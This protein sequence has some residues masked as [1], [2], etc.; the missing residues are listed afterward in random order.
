VPQPS[1]GHRYGGLGRRT[2]ATRDP[3]SPRWAPGTNGARLVARRTEKTRSVGSPTRSVRP[4]RRPTAPRRALPRPRDS[5]WWLFGYA[6][7]LVGDQIFYVALTWVAVTIMSPAE[8]GL[9][10]VLGSLPRAVV[11]LAGGVFVDRIGPKRVIIVSDVLRT[12][13]MVAAAVLFGIGA[14]GTLLIG[15]LAAVFGVV[16]GFF[17][18]A[19]G[20]APAFVA[21]LEAQTRLQALRTVVYRGAPMVGAPLAS[22]LLVAYGAVSAFGVAAFMFAASV[23]AL[24]LTRMTRPRPEEDDPS[25]PVG[26]AQ[27]VFAEIRDGLRLVSRDRRL[28]VTVVVLAV[29]DF[30][31][32]GPMTA[33]VPLLAAERGWGAGGIGWVLGGFGVGAVVTAVLLTWRRPTVRAGVVAATGLTLMSLGLLALGLV[34]LAGLAPADEVV[35]AG[36]CG[37]LAGVG[38]GLFGTLINASL[39]I[40]TPV[41]QL[42][43][44]M[45]VAALA[46]YVGDPV[47]FSLTGITSQVLGASS[48]FLFGGGF[49]MV[50]VVIT[51]VSPAIRTLALPGTERRA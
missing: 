23:V 44:V 9:V 39:V 3:G 32:A 21:T 22:A 47:S 16:D 7:S 37:A 42:G 46:G 31:F 8:V 40:S 29:L 14:N 11:L 33:G 51:W 10:L 41:R 27:G 26:A 45:A 35:L 17:L 19:V 20:A 1:D 34:D 12:L 15:A 5:G 6:H 49:I 13:V 18:P 2:A 50:A 36:V 43:R 28:L 25:G 4:E 38:T 48:A 30:G 24:A